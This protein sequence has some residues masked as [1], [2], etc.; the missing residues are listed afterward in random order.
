VLL[1]LVTVSL[2]ALADGGYW[3]TTWGWASLIL[4]WLACIAVIVADVRVGLLEL[5]MVGLL[6]AFMLWTALSTTWSESVTASVSEVERTAVYVAL[7]AAALV[8]VRARAYKRLV[9]GIWAAVTLVAL[10]SLATRLV[11]DRF[12]VFDGTASYR[13]SEPIGYWNALGAFAVIGELLAFG[14][15]ARARS[16]ALRAAAAGSLVVLMTT[17]YFTF[18]RGPWLALGL[19]LA[20]AV[21]IDARRLQLVTTGLVLAPFAALAVWLA[22]RSD[23]LTHLR[24]GI[25]EATADGHELA[26][27]LVILVACAALTAVA[28][29][30]VEGHVDFSHHVRLTYGVTLLAAAVLLL[31]VVFARWGSPWTLAQRTYDD[32]TRPPRAIGTDLNRRL[33]DL[34]NSGRLDQWK[35]AWHDVRE[36]PV[37]GSGAGTYEQE[38]DRER[39]VPG[40]VRDAHNLYLETLAELGPVG[41][42]LLVAA[43]LLPLAAAIRAR[44][45]GLVPAIAGAYVA[46]LVH[47]TVDWDWELPA[48]TTAALLCGVALLL[49]ARLESRPRLLA[50][51]GRAVAA[52]AAAALALWSSV[53]LVGNSALASMADA[54]K[55]DDVSA[56]RARAEKARE[57]APWSS[58]PHY[59]LGY[60]DQIRGNRSA[61]LGH[62]RDAVER[63]PNVWQLR[64]TLAGVARGRER[65]EALERAHELNPIGARA[66]ARPR[67]ENHIAP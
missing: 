35:V 62:Y 61:A 30:L 41:L 7:L 49:A 44:S 21:V 38:W 14:L 17:V 65:S 4:A 56:A 67:E 9:V 37:V 39:P 3:P 54:L 42:T 10:Y 32:F 1:G 48:V 28:L 5:A 47:A 51:R 60:L 13:L 53:G 6:A 59:W 64:L 34:S 31:A 12:G 55:D 27:V 29:G 43:L 22:S 58:E 63:D 8:G 2:L 20:A 66:P 25:S 16:L 18:G 45:R 36:H 46:F 33:F 40:R 19:G 23:A 50:S 52:G 24:A 26:L 15:A 11:P 57:W